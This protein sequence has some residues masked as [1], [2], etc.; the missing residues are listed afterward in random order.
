MEIKYLTNLHYL[1][2]FALVQ[3]AKIFIFLDY[4]CNSTS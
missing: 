2:A 4:F 1:D 3:K